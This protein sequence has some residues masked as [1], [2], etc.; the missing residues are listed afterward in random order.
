MIGNFWQL[1]IVLFI[2]FLLFS[3]FNSII[4]NIKK[5]INKNLN[6]LKKKG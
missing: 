2:I 1:L 5:I 3:D 4:K 6:K